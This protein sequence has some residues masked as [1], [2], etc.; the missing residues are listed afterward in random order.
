[1][2]T[3]FCVEFQS[4]SKGVLPIFDAPYHRGLEARWSW[5]W[6]WSH[7]VRFCLLK[8]WGIPFKKVAICCDFIICCSYQKVKCLCL[9]HDWNNERRMRHTL[10]ENC[11]NMEFFL[12]RIFL[13]SDWIQEIRIRKNCVFGLF[14]R[15][16]IH[17]LSVCVS[18]DSLS[19]LIGIIEKEKQ[20]RHHKKC[21]QKNQLKL[22]IR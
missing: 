6:D 8:C 21:T 7:L 9:K 19:R 10:R 1:M 13:Y 15:S 5:Y 22:K 18:E 20:W 2:K 14:S 4:P 17:R 16:D 3:L 11:P 12:V